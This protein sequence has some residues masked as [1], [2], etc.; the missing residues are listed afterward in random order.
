[1]DMLTGFLSALFWGL[2]TFS[3]LVFIHEGGHF[4]AARACGVR[5]T[6][7]FLGLPCSVNIHHTSRRI[8]TRFGVT[9]LLLGGYAAVCGMD[10]IDEPC[11]PT[12]LAAV[13]RAGSISTYE[14]ARQLDL[15][16][17]SVQDACAQLLGWGSLAPVYEE[18]ER[19][20]ATHYPD[21]YAAMPRDASGATVFD[22]RKFDRAHATAEGEPWEPTMGER[23]FYEQERSRTYAGV[24]FWRRAFILAAG[25]I[26]NVVAGIL[27]FVIVYA[28]IGFD[29]PVDI[30]RLGSV[31][32]GSP[33]A[34]AG[35]E[36]GDTVL[37]VN[38]TQTETWQDVYLALQDALDAADEGS[39]TGDDTGAS[40]IT[41]TCDRDGS[42]F[43]TQV[44]P[45]ADGMIGI[46]VPYERVRLAP[47]DALRV[48]F[49]YIAQTAS[50]VAQLLVPS[51]TLEV[52]D[53][54]TSV[55]GISSMAAQAAASGAAVY[56]SFAGL[57][58]LSLGFMNLLPIPPLDGG[59]LLI[60]A[61]QAIAHRKVP[62]R[63]QL[64]V[65][66]I[67]IALFVALFL[68]VL[69]GDILRLL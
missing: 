65:S 18:G 56:L 5:V 38:G 15:P 21:V 7:F 16:E 46:A 57:I 68:Y 66:Y 59:K 25:V 24:G 45:D 8:G 40:E 26:V 17:T 27:L 14:L 29:M 55:V 35:L 63:V 61:I 32:A 1:M 34:E 41:L 11:A 12:V 43:T 58:S 64:I 36:A 30:N 4:L 6:E 22:G 13:H 28:A 49:D 67:G 60:E 44:A 31:E 54:S 47:L 3:A 53:N 19:P 48:S 37:A 33:A 62:M 23:A 50:G 51:R 10:G 52:L 9:P 39:T 20:S 69:R 42:E 2:V